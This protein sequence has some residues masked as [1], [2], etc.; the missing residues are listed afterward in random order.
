MKLKN[1]DTGEIVSTS[2]DFCSD[3]MKLFC[4]ETHKVYTVRSLAELNEIFEDVEGPGGYWFI[5]SDNKHIA[6]CDENEEAEKDK[7]SG[8]YFTTL[9]EAEKAIKD[10]EK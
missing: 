8:N 4:E 3:Y 9:E 6:F 10:K 7:A 1:K 5:T 2:R